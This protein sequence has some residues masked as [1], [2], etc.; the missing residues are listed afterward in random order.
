MDYH[1]KVVGG[2]PAPSAYAIKDGMD[3][4]ENKK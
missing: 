2:L 4:T 1:L 3:Q